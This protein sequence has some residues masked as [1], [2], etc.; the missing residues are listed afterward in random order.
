MIADRG[1][2][3]LDG[4]L[5]R[6]FDKFFRSAVAASGGTGL[7]LPIAKGFIEAQHGRLTAKNRRNGGAEFIIALPIEVTTEAE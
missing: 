1:K 5:S 6:I 3:I 2:G 4:D 7:G